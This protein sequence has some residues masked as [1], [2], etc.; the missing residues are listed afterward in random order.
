MPFAAC[1]GVRHRLSCECWAGYPLS[2]SLT[3]LQAPIVRQARVLSKAK[4]TSRD[5]VEASARV[6]MSRCATRACGSNTNTCTHMQLVGEVRPPHTTAQSAHLHTHTYT[7]TPSPTSASTRRS[8]QG[9]PSS[10][11][12]HAKTYSMGCE[13]ATPSSQSQQSSSAAS[14]G[15]S[16]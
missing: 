5:L 6:A 13:P 16:P 12:G 3:P 1:I 14:K 4:D 2:L 9:L 10:C 8:P 7:H 11:S 15:T